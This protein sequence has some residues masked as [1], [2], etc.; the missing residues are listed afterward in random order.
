MLNENLGKLPTQNEWDEWK[1]HPCT[2]RLR[3]WA[4]QSRMDLM[5]AW[6]SGTFSA[7]FSIEMAVKNAGATGACSV[8]ENLI[9]PEYNQIVIGATDEV[10]EPEKLKQDGAEPPGASSAG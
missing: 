7:A 5:E 9:E 10:K 3:F 6:A 2:K 1:L 4:Q 8:F